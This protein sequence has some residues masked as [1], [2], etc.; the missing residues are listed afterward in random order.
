[1]LDQNKPSV[2]EVQVAGEIVASGSAGYATPESNANVELERLY[3]SAQSRWAEQAIK[4]N[5]FFHNAQFTD[6]QVDQLTA[7]GLAAVPVNVIYP[8][9]EQAIAML[10]T[11]K[12][13][14]QA[15]AR[16]DSDVKTA[17]VIAD[18]MTWIWE[19]SDGN[20][21]L[22]TACYDYYVKGRGVLMAYVNPHADFGRGDICIADVDPLDV[23][24]DP[25]SRDRYWRDASNIIVSRIFTQEQLLNMWPDLA[26]TDLLAHAGQD[27]SYWNSLGTMAMQQGQQLGQIPVRDPHHRRFKVIE[28]Y[29]KTKVRYV[30]VE[31][32]TTGE[33]KVLLKSELKDYLAQPAAYVS[34]GGQSRFVSSEGE[35]AQVMQMYQAGVDQGNGVRVYQ[36]PP[37]MDPATGQAVQMAPVAIQMMTNEQLVEAGAIRLANVLLDRIKLCI[38]IGNQQYWLGYLPIKD[39]PIVPLNNRH[40]RNPY[41]MSDV[42]IVQS[43]QESL[44]KIHMQ[45]I[46]NISSGNNQKLITPRGSVDREQVEVELGK[47][48][49]AVIEV[50]YELGEPKLWGPSPMPVGLFTYFQQI[51]SQI[52][53]ELGIFSFMGGDSQN[54]P[55]TYKGTLALDEF[56]QRRVRSKL[57]DI[58]GALNQLGK[59]CVQLMPYVYTEEKVV[60]LVQPNNTVVESVA[61]QLTYDDLGR[62]TGRINDVSL[63][64]YD[65]VVV[66]GSTLPSNRWALA[67]YYQQL[68]TNGLIDQVEALKKTELVDAEGVLQRASYIKQLE[69]M[70]TQLQEENKNLKGDLQTAERAEVNSRKRVEVAKFQAAL[71]EPKANAQKAAVIFETRLNDQMRLIEAERKASNKNTGE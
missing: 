4:L 36:A 58:E 57:D 45:I 30:R 31:D 5:A 20:V 23:L 62:I 9:V 66:S 35:I 54:A 33:E 51:K 24:P 13:R 17:K 7:R 27:E 12:P 55:E 14:F 41:C 42:G 2:D 32:G 6:E 43:L 71:A 11:N 16:E 39:Y 49:A 48:G 28:R 65:I 67:E 63:G 50:D 70:V 64:T 69:A 25:N 56:G 1:M 29:T 3:L 59:V 68:Y 10:T 52:E 21:H 40:D 47:T 19:Q 22:K 46:A 53:Q 34:A 15:T 8:A 60:R 61:N 44:N 18:L 37:Q 38:S 26:D